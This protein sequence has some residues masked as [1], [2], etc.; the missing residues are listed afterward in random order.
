MLKQLFHF[1]QCIDRQ[2]AHRMRFSDSCFRQLPGA[3]AGHELLLR[4]CLWYDLKYLSFNICQGVRKTTKT[5]FRK[6]ALCFETETPARHMVT[7]R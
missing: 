7:K 3:S 2:H 4:L 5:L 6:K 1:F